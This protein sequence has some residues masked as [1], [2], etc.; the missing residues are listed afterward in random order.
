M[1]GTR[2]GETLRTKALDDF[3]LAVAHAGYEWT[4]EMRSAYE[5]GIRESRWVGLTDYQKLKFAEKFRIALFAIE[6]IEAKLKEK[7]T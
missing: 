2:R 6:E 1:V 5:K 7:N 4:P 3:A